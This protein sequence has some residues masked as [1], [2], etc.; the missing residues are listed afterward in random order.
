MQS[1]SI[2]GHSIWISGKG[3]EHISGFSRFL[4]TASKDG[5]ALLTISLGDN[6]LQNWEIEPLYRSVYEGTTCDFARNGNRYLFRM[7]TQKNT[8]LLLEI[9]PLEDAFLAI[10]NMDENTSEY[11]LYLAV[12]MAFSIAAVHRQITLIHASTVIYKEKSI[13]FLGESG[14][15]KSTHSQ[16]W[17]QNIPDTKLLNDDSPLLCLK[18]GKKVYACGSP[19]SGKTACYKNEQ[20][21]VAG[22]VRLSQAPYNQ[23]KRLT[24]IAAIGALLPSCPP[25][26]AYDDLLSDH[27]HKII[28][29]VL[30]QIPVYSLSCLPDAEAA[31]LVF[32][33]LKNEGRL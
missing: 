12:W 7:T 28:S 8:P 3:M 6:T 27:V 11:M 26:F 18:D 23:I 9:Y 21:P 30:Q 29:I 31:Q 16:L 33:T 32:Q 5:E 20:A 1:Y 4:F 24:G 10:T 2:A 14:T 13:L 19:W 22:I 15:G 25:H 17:L